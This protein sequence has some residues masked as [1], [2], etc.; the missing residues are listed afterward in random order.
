MNLSAL[1]IED[2]A[3]THPEVAHARALH[4]H[5]CGVK[6]V[7]ELCVG[8]SAPV[9]H[10]AY[11]QVGISPLFNDID[12]R[13]SASFPEYQ[14]V[15]RDCFAAAHFCLRAG[16]LLDLVVFAPPL[17]AGCTGTREDSLMIEEVVPS[18]WAWLRL[19][20]D[21]PARPLTCTVLPARSL[22]TRHDKAQFYALREGFYKLGPPEVIERTVG[23]RQI[24]KYVEIWLPPG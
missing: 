16:P 2:T 24:R 9:L 22:S 7:L 11:R 10:E 4:A 1:P 20:A 15:G 23:A 5:H 17:S 8:P 3:S 14:W 21:L 18:Y 6:T 19:L 13:W 12:P